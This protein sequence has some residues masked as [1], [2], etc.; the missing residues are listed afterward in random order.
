MNDELALQFRIANI[1]T[2][3]FAV[4]EENYN[5][6]EEVGLS[7]SLDF[8]FD[9]NNRVLGVDVKFQFMQDEKAFLI[10]K[11]RCEFE[12]EGE[13]WNS[14]ISENTITVPEGFAS[15]LAVITVGTARGV[16]HEKT[17]DTSFNHFVIPTI[18]LTALI[19]E[20]VVLDID[21]DSEE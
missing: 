21:A 8:G 20:D 1:N 13:A 10:L 16:L 17:N 12:I 5:E 18:N 15:H 4:L 14:F 3:E 2:L 7:T 11:T 6:P 9:E 19:K